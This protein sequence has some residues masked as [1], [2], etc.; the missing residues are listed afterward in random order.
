M[1]HSAATYTIIK[2]CLHALQPCK[3]HKLWTI[4]YLLFLKRTISFFPI[5]G[6][7]RCI[8]KYKKTIYLGKPP[9]LVFPSFSRIPSGK[10]YFSKRLRKAYHFFCCSRDKWNGSLCKTTI[11]TYAL[12]FG[13]MALANIRRKIFSLILYWWVA[14]HQGRLCTRLSN[15]LYF[16]F[17]QFPCDPRLLETIKWHWLQ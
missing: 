6:R 2:P 9:S 7:P 11:C 15:N 13:S 1:A 17:W 4:I 16:H 8:Y 5:V 12:C 14:K 3:F 10:A